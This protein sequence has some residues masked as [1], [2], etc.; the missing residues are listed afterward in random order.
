MIFQHCYLDSVDN[1]IFPD[2]KKRCGRADSV[3]FPK[4]RVQ[5]WRKRRALG[6]VIPR[7]GCILSKE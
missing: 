3:Y 5:G 1:A 6:C 7:V 4:D 2:A